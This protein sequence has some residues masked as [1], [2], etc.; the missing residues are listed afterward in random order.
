MGN[1][2]GKEQASALSHSGL[3]TAFSKQLSNQHFKNPNCPFAFI[4]ALQ[5][6]YTLSP[7]FFPSLVGTCKS[8]VPWKHKTQTKND[9]G[10]RGQDGPGH[11]PL[12]LPKCRTPEFLFRSRRLFIRTPTPYIDN[13]VLIYIN[14][15]KEKAFFFLKKLTSFQELVCFSLVTLSFEIQPRGNSS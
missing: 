5:T 6:L 9:P 3:C 14:R 11:Q 4:S 15:A 13:V 12:H 8:L 10:P 2:R 1:G 7:F